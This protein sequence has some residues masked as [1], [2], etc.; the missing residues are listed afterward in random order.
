MNKR[1]TFIIGGTLLILVIGLVV[2]VLL[3]QEP[4][5]FFKRATAPLCPLDSATCRW[6]YS[7]TG[8]QFNV[9][10]VDQTTGQTV[11]NTTTTAKEVIFSPMV[12]HV[13]RCT[14]VPKNEC[15]DGQSQETTG[16]CVGVG[17][18]TPTPSNTPTPTETPTP[19]LTATPTPTPSVCEVPP[20]ECLPAADCSDQ[21]REAG[22]EDCS[23]AGVGYVCCMPF[24]TTPTPTNTPTPT[25]TP[26][27]TGTPTPTHTV[28]P[29]NTP[30]PPP[31]STSTPTP[32]PG[33]TATPTPPPGAT[34]TPTPTNTP[35]PPSIAQAS[36]TLTD[37]PIPLP[38]VPVAGGFLPTIF[39]FIGGALVVLAAL[40]L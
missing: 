34:Y 21:G 8:V 15:G 11:V 26:T 39:T 38:D 14:V 25:E 31:G 23:S 1:K 17:T 32:P 36:P 24:G 29:T 37:T 3:S 7:A 20:N 30:T 12:G 4:Q 33:S 22:N 16:V 13:Y 19:A 10:V 2:G 35:T 9:T 18:P 27:P 5:L 6:D 28:T 40:L